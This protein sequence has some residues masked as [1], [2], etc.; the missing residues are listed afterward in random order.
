MLR[1]VL[2]VK[3]EDMVYWASSVDYYWQS[4]GRNSDEKH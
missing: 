3:E 1:N 2:Y 4:T